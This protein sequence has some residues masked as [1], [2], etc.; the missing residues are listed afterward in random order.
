MLEKHL[1]C[2]ALLD[3]V[4]IFLR[5]LDPKNDKMFADPKLIEHWMPVDLYIGG[6]EH[7][8]GHLLY[9]RMWNNFLFDQEVG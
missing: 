3:R 1:Q 9:S 8:V 4:G 5:Y 7:A 6:P 2:Q